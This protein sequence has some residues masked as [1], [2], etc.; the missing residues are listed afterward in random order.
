MRML[1]RDLTRKTT[2]VGSIINFFMSVTA[3]LRNAI[4]LKRSIK[5]SIKNAG[6]DNHCNF[7]EDYF[8]ISRWECS[9]IEAKPCSEGDG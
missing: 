6:S 9:L 3:Q 5:D 8:L 1:G 2:I 4:I 7:V